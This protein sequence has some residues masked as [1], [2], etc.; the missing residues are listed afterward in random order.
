[1]LAHHK[2]AFFKAADTLNCWIGL[3]EPNELSDRYIGKGGYVAKNE[4]CKA[5]SADNPAY[6]YKG[7]VVNPELCPEAFLASSLPEA[8]K[9][10]KSFAAGMPAGFSYKQSGALKGLVKF[11][12][13]SIHADFDLMYVSKAD[14]SGKMIFTTTQE[15]H[16]LSRKAAT[17]LNS[18][19]GADMI[20]HGAELGWKGDTKNNIRVG[21]RESE[22]I[23][24]FG[25]KKQF[26]QDVSSMSDKAG[27]MH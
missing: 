25:P 14:G 24:S 8:Q 16:E 22:N 2:E 19:L 12:G 15:Q 3:R 11:N 5:K 7:L 23:W 10:W 9:K 18:L 13:K 17:L 1:M 26:R 6:Q 21:A 27:K 4:N 20:L